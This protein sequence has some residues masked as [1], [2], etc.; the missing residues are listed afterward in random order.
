MN[1]LFDT[2]ESVIREY[3]GSRSQIMRWTI[4]PDDRPWIVKTFEDRFPTVRYLALDPPFA[5]VTQH[6]FALASAAYASLAGDAVPRGSFR[7]P[8]MAGVHKDTDAF[9]LV[10]NAY[11]RSVAATSGKSLV[12][13]IDIA[14]GPNDARALAG[15]WASLLRTVAGL[16][17]RFIACE[18]RGAVSAFDQIAT[19]VRPM[20]RH[21]TRP[22]GVPEALEAFA[23]AVDGKTPEGQ[24]RSLLLKVM[25]ACKRRD[26]ATAMQQITAVSSLGTSIG[27]PDLAVPGWFSVSALAMARS[28]YAA[29]I[30]RYRQA[31]T[32]A[33]RAKA[34]S[35]PAAGVLVVQSRMGVGSALFGGAGYEL[36]GRYF[37]ETVPLALAE[38][39]TRL[40]VECARL[41]GEAYALARKVESA[42]EAGVV[43]LSTLARV[44]EGERPKDA[45]REL[46]LFLRRLTGRGPASHHRMGVDRQLERLLGAGWD[47][48]PT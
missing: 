40:E 14:Y 21:E 16:P 45:G 12:V 8:S 28:D 3:G 29:A 7:P 18:A 34:L 2:I 13:D 30:E 22:L 32:H 19:D 17:V 44:P 37:L 46:G 33:E 35:L 24:M 6:G 20:I 38:G 36:A 48:V 1:G 9:A 4:D 39:E 26:E 23:L 41:A 47:H 5:S 27:R 10:L 11:L 15:W 42:F 43:G 31:V 25:H